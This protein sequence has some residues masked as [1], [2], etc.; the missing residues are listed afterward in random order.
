MG[1][2]PSEERDAQGRW[3]AGGGDS[4]GKDRLTMADLHARGITT[5][6]WNLRDPAKMTNSEI[7]KERDR[8]SKVSSQI[9]SDFIQQGRGHE[10][11]NETVK[12]SDP[13]SQRYIAVSNRHHELRVEAEKR[14]GPGLIGHLPPKNRSF[15]IGRRPRVKKL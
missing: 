9:N 12:K 11:P 3:T 5:T 10:T 2:D 7:N 14:Y 1:F 13:L 15:T 6:R 4:L 8:L